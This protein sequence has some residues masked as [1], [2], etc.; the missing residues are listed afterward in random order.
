MPGLVGWI[1]A[2]VDSEDPALECTRYDGCR[3]VEEL[4]SEGSLR[5]LGS[6][7]EFG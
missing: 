4:A 6:D 5:E 1:E 7:A 2:E 3:V